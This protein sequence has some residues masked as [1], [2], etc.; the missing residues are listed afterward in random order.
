VGCI[1]YAVSAEKFWCHFSKINH[2][3]FLVVCD[4]TMTKDLDIE[5][6]FHN[7]ENINKTNGIYQKNVSLSQN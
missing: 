2:I 6:L 7:E 3:L 4:M 5:F 1:K